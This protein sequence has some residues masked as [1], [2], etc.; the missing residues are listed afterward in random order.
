[1][2]K[3]DLR[4]TVKVMKALSHENRL[5]LLLEIASKHS[6]EIDSDALP[7]GCFIADIKELFNIGAP[8]LSHHLKELAN[9]DLIT[10]EKRGKHVV[11]T[12]NVA[13]LRSVITF[14]SQ[15]TS[16]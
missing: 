10:T 8:T 3:H 9:A 12:V 2:D 1:M 7:E 11:A 14:L 6:T 15:A 5:E 4:R 16:H 13:T